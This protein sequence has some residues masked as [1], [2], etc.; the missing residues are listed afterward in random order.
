MGALRN[1]LKILF[2]EQNVEAL[3][4]NFC[5]FSDSKNWQCA[6]INK[7]TYISAYTNVFSSN[8]QDQAAAAFGIAATKWCRPDNN[9]NFT[10]CSSDNIFNVL[11]HFSTQILL[12]RDNKPVCR[13]EQLLKWH[14]VT[15]SLGEDMFTTSF[16]ASSDISARRNRISFSWTSLVDHDNS[17]LHQLYK[18]EM[19]DIHN[20]LNGNG[21]IAELNWLSLMNDVTQRRCQFQSKGMSK[22]KAFR[23]YYGTDCHDTSLYVKVMKAAAIRLC[24]FDKAIGNTNPALSVKDLCKILK[25]K[26]D[27]GIDMWLTTITSAIVST[28]YIYANRFDTAAFNKCCVDYAIL[29]NAFFRSENPANDIN[30]V[31]SGERFILYNIFRKIYADEDKG[32]L[33]S[34]LLYIY[35][36]IKCELSQELVQTN[37]SVGFANFQEYQDRK[38]TFLKENTVYNHLLTQTAIRSI[39]D[40]KKDRYLETRICPNQTEKALARQLRDCD[41][42]AYCINGQNLASCLQSDKRE[43][44]DWHYVAHFIKKPDKSTKK[45]GIQNPR[46]HNV[47]Q[48]VKHQCFAIDNLRHFNYDMAKRL[49][50]IDAASSELCCRPEVFAQ[51][52]RFLRNSKPERTLNNDRLPD[53]GV[54][55]HVGEDFNDIVDGLRATR[56]AM[57]FLGM[58]NGDRIGHGLVLGTDVEHY[59]RNRSYAVPMSRQNILD[60]MAFL[61]VEASNLDGFSKISMWLIRQFENHLTEIYGKY[62]RDCNVTPFT[63]Y[64]SWLLRGDNPSVY[65]EQESEP[66]HTEIESHAWNQSSLVMDRPQVDAR[67]N[68]TARR[69]YHLYHFNGTVKERGNSYDQLEYP[70]E[71]IPVIEQLQEKILTEIEAKHISIE[72]NPSSNYK[73]GEITKFIEHPITRFNMISRP[74]EGKM[75]NLCVSINTDDKGVFSTSLEREFALMAAAYDKEYQHDP[76]NAPT[77]REVYTWLD[78]IRKMGNEMKFHKT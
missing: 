34:M 22:S 26:S 70:K 5:R 71:V 63:Y 25:Q 41:N 59:Y 28:Q 49:V 62:V 61:L 42:I 30:F 11:L 69:L 12:E 44:K 52:F 2:N 55:Y 47:R 77:P 16:L 32:N 7:D 24:L 68:V 8:T 38:S 76:E 72:C 27:V 56:E 48:T 74:K 65:A 36:I 23:T 50:G 54:T 9:G 31:L 37:A 66:L 60:N 4:D 75:H 39:I 15:Y 20:H 67:R 43:I 78:N 64:Q 6:S 58:R 1:T 33:L 17:A 40:N 51:G 45:E 35:L 13:F 18:E 3:I 29:R 46:N 53:L 14:E 73:I 10:F 57:M 19:S 21:Y